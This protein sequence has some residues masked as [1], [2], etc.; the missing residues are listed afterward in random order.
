MRCRAAGG[1]AVALLM[2]L[3]AT[4][5]AQT[6]PDAPPDPADM[7][8]WQVSV[9]DSADCLRGVD[10]NP[11][12]ALVRPRMPTAESMGLVGLDDTAKPNDREREVLVRY[13]EAAATC[14][15]QFFD[16]EDDPVGRQVARLFD[17]LWAEQTV[18]LRR[19]AEGMLTWGRYNRD[20]MG[21]DRALRKKLAAIR[22]HPEKN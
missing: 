22:S 13:A 15:P 17:T 7:P 20:S 8:A 11:A 1:G 2:G 21:L 14:V 5:S 4:A 12:F 10:A 9:A 3:V 18:L 19:L 6:S 16:L